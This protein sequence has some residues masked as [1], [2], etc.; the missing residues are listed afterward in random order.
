MG[1]ESI[2]FTLAEVCNLIPD[3]IKRYRQIKLDDYSKTIM[4]IKILLFS[5]F[6]SNNGWPVP[7]PVIDD[8]TVIESAIAGLDLIKYRMWEIDHYLHQDLAT[9]ELTLLS[10]QLVTHT[11]DYHNCEYLT[12]LQSCVELFNTDIQL[13]DA[14]DEFNRIIKLRDDYIRVLDNII[15]D[16]EI[17][18]NEY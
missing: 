10:S 14:Y 12:R 8:K 17:R 6:N 7:K 5:S 13:R 9:K 16:I 2:P 4:P 15:A 11:K 1:I 3:A 18:I